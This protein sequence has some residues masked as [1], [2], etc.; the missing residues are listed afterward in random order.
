MPG[1]GRRAY[2]GYLEERARDREGALSD[3]S[4]RQL[5]RGWCLGDDTFRDKVL[6]ALVGG[7]RSKRRKGNVTGG[8]A[9]AHDEAEAER[10]VLV[11]I[12][13]LIIP[14]KH[15]ALAGRGGYRDEKALS[16]WL[17]RKQTSVS[18]NWMA[19]RLAMGHPTSVSRAA[20]RVR[21]EAGLARRGK[22]LEKRVMQH[23]T[24]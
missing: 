3:E 4:L 8:A 1:R 17:L 9:R 6:D 13:E 22:M 14:G 5:R 20:A 11:A 24:A 21:T 2:S 18:R 10:I 12:D 7:I 15:G 16:S 19:E 23:I